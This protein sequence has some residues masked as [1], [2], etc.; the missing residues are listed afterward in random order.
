M[1]QR[2]DIEVLLSHYGSEAQRLASFALLTLGVVESLAAG[3]IT[4]P[5]AVEVY[6]HADN[7]LYVRRQLRHE[8]ADDI[9]GRGVQLPDL[10]DALPVD[11]A[12]QEFQREIVTM[13]TLCLALLN[14]QRLAA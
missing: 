13:R 5:A 8:V 3:A 6:F 11:E 4:I 2:V 12:Q 7:C 1:K 14:D 10:F 9:M